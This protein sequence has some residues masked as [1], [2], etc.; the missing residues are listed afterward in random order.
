MGA[1]R[2]HVAMEEAE[3]RR[4]RHVLCFKKTGRR[5]THGASAS[6]R[7]RCESST[8]GWHPPPITSS[9]TPRLTLISGDRFER[10]AFTCCFGF[11]QLA[12]APPPPL[13][14]TP[15]ARR[16]ALQLSAFGEVRRVPSTPALSV[17]PDAQA[18]VVS[19][20]GWWA[21][22]R[23]LSIGARIP[24]H[25]RSCWHIALDDVGAAVGVS[26]RPGYG[27]GGLVKMGGRCLSAVRPPST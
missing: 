20:F 22:P 13:P 8:G 11:E 4:L 26:W 9:T 21:L 10:G 19:L 18:P 5:G 12:L 15:A 16:H 3:R 24:V 6:M 14:S 27:R 2:A 1:R 25:L 23:H 17:R 7:T